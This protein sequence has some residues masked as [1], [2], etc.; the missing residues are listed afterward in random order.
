MNEQLTPGPVLDMA[1]DAPGDLTVGGVTV[2]SGVLLRLTAE[3]A[4]DIEYCLFSAASR[5]V[6]AQ[7]RN[8]F[9]ALLARIGP[10]GKN[11]VSP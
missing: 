9:R 8:R 3:D 6:N 7:R 11:L 4:A 5:I 10:S 2:D 1:P